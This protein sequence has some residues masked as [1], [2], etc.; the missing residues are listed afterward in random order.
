MQQLNEAENHIKFLTE[1]I[2]NLKL[3]ENKL[4]EA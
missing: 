2:E 1:E 3:L 4:K